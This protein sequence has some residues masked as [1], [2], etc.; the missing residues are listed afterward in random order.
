[1]TKKFNNKTTEKSTLKNWYSLM[2]LGRILDERAP[3]YLKQ[4]I[5]WSYHAPYAGHDGI[6]LGTLLDGVG[7]NTSTQYTER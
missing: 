7:N 1:M 2:S 4:A 3:N 6:Q 5:G